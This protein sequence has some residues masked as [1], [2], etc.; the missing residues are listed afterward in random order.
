MKAQITLIALLISINLA[1]YGQ[2]TKTEKDKKVCFSIE[3]LEEEEFWNTIVYPRP[4]FNNEEL[5]NYLAKKVSY[6]ELAKKNARSASFLVPLH[7]STKGKA[8]LAAMTTNGNSEFEDIAIDILTDSKLEWLPTNKNK[9]PFDAIVH[10]PVSFY[11][12]CINDV[13]YYKVQLFI[14][15]PAFTIDSTNTFP[16]LIVIDGEDRCTTNEREFLTSFGWNNSKPYGAVSVAFEIDTLG[17]I[18]EQKVT[19]LISEDLNDLALSFVNSTSGKWISARRNG[20]K[21]PSYKYF[22]CLFDDI[23]VFEKEPIFKGF[24]YDLQMN[25]IKAYYSIRR[26]KYIEELNRIKHLNEITLSLF[27]KLSA[28]QLLS[29]NKYQE[30]LEQFNRACKYYYRDANLFFNRSIANHYVGNKEKSCEDLQSVLD[31]AETEGFPHGITKKQVEDL[32]IKF[33]Q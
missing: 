12:Q 3:Q 19:T 10:V 2:K 18:A 29:E 21:V 25:G 20:V 17:A 13:L 24:V 27:D 28:M 9:K 23:Y 22:W 7:I 31:I 30:S 4:A 26:D 11:L 6:P 33:C 32:I 15:F 16:A 5:R 1:A 14:N 8:T